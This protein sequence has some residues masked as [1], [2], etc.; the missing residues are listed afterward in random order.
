MKRALVILAT[1][2]LL[3]ACSGGSGDTATTTQSAAPK[4]GSTDIN[5]QPR[6]ALKTGGTLNLSIQQWITQYNVGQVDGTQ[7]DGQAILAMTQ[8]R[9]WHLDESA[10]ATV[11]PDVLVSAEAAG[12]VVT[13]KLNPLATWSDQTPIT[14]QDFATQWKTRNGTDKRF[15]LS[16]STGYDSI[17]GVEKGADDREVKVTFR[18]PYA[19]W[20]SLFDP[21]LPG[22]ALDTPEKFNTGWIE[23]VPVWGGPWKIGTADKTAQTIT[24]VP[25][26]D[27]WGTK[28]VLDKV[29]FRALDS[30]AITDAY[31][32]KEIDQ[33]PARQPD[34]YKRVAGDAT[35]KIRTGGRWDE[36]ILSLGSKGPLADVRVR[37]A[38]GAAIDRDAIA[39]AQSSGLPFAVHTVGNHFYMP[40]QD[41]Y[42]DNAGEYGKLDLDRAKSL[43]KEAGY[44]GAKLVYVV[45]ASSTSTVPQLVQ[46][47]LSQAGINV[48]LRKVPGN[49]FFEKYVNRGSFDLVSFRNVDQVF[50]SLSYPAFLSNGEQN[51][52]KIG[53]PEI[54]KLIARA[55][56]ETDHAK[57]ATLL[58]QVDAL[59][60][61]EEH[62]IALF[63]TPQ[64]LAVRD[65]LANF[66]AYGLRDDRQYTEVGFVK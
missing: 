7:G 30:A 42:A 13:Y 40:S 8:P 32:N 2:T 24:L 43:L 48:E 16:G 23:K 53:S 37:Q 25:N 57:Q 10:K 9:L 58:N 61:Q 54:D 60:W 4:T 21:L 6:D 35:T 11:N 41:G 18:E 39:K 50:P 52:G 63:Q 51:Y 66:G 44:T 26:P 45:S 65:G 46:N 49:D 1:A 3:A 19:D 29:V 56:V 31:L 15:Q 14:W 64:I 47:M 36:T 20:Q 62:S 28:P 34:D 38:I 59:L 55:A 27:Y 22:S 33:A 17:T 5:A 12:P